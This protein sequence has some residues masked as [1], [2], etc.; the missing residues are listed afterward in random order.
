[1]KNKLKWMMA[2]GMLSCSV[3]MAQQQ[4]D[5][6]S[7]SASTNVENAALA[8][9]KNM[10]TMWTLPSQALKSGQW[11]MFTIQQPGDVYE[12]ELQMQ[13]YS[14]VGFPDGDFSYPSFA[15]GYPENGTPS[16]YES[17]S[18]SLN[19]YFNA[20]YSFDD[21]YLMDFSLRTSGSSVFG[22]SRKYNTTWSVGLGW[23]HE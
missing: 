10:K 23:L 9:D 16:Y 18:R 19:G 13:G 11:L 12:L 20:G 21:R 5:I 3:A 2:V 1:M 14:A 7:V 6:M 15:N 22:T 8:F 17:E 4:S